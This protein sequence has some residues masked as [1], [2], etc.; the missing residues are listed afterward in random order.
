MY[1]VAT[2]NVQA[3]DLPFSIAIGSGTRIFLRGSGPTIADYLGSCYVAIARVG[4]LRPHRLWQYLA[5]DGRHKGA[6]LARKIPG[7][8]LR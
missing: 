2:K 5:L 8:G 6:R 4:E 7:I 3:R 1:C